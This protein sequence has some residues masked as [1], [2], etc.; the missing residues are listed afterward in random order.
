MIKAER[1]ARVAWKGDLASG[2]GRV[3][4]G[5]GSLPE[6]PVSWPS[7]VEDPGGQTSPEELIASAHASCFAMA[8][9]AE[10]QKAGFTPDRLDIEARSL[11]DDSGEGLS[12]KTMHLDVRG[13]A[14]GADEAGFRQAA[15]AA[16]E[17][18]PV[19]QAL[20][21]NVQISLQVTLE[22]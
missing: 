12:I 5:S 21:G 14:G 11:I 19:S 2:N 18:C 22:Q 9:S 13:F 3:T 10:L 17:G 15:E 16:A 7:R 8:M 20:K 6:F 1:T 4:V